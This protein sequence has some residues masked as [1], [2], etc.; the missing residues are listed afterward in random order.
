MSNRKRNLGGKKIIGK[1]GKRGQRKRRKNPWKP[2]KPDK[3]DKQACAKQGSGPVGMSASCI[4]P[5]V[6]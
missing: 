1:I 4:E 6:A 3:L 5:N 2:S